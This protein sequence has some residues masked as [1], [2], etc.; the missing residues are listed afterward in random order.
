MTIETR[1][2]IDWWEYYLAWRS[3]KRANGDAPPEKVAGFMLALTGLTIWM[4]GGSGL[5]AIG[6]IV[7]G[8]L[9]LTGIPLLRRA[10]IRR[11]WANEPHH[12]AEHLFVFG[13]DNVHHQQNEVSSDL[14]WLFYSRLVEQENGFLLVC[15]DDVFSLIPKRA[16]AS[17]EALGDFRALASRRL[18]KR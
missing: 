7:I 2:H 12:Q 3:F 8:A 5:F 14:P 16:F 17:Q 11:R 9:V 10:E 4:F 18:R 15:G 13:E 6:G 1:F